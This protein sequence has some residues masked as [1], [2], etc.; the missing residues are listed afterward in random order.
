M[1]L[2]RELLR[3]IRREPVR[4]ML[5]LLGIMI[6]SGAVVLLAST[7]KAAT[8]ALDRASQEATGDDITRVERRTP[9]PAAMARLAPGLSD[10]D[11]RA[12]ADREHVPSGS[13]AVSASIYHQDA[14]VG[15]KTKPVGVQSGGARY[16]RLS[17]F[18]VLHGRWMTPEEDGQRL[19][20]IGHDVWKDLFEEQWPLRQDALVLN[21][22]TRLTVV[23]VLAPRPPIGGG[24]GDGTWMVDRRVIVSNPTFARA[25]APIEEYDEI[26]IKGEPRNGKVPDRIAVAG[27]LSPLVQNLHM[28]VKNFEFDALGKGMQVDMLIA[29]AL[30]V[31]LLGCALVATVVGAVNV[32]NAQLVQ[33]H[34]RTREY[35]IC[36]ALG[37]S[38]S[39][40]RLRVLLEALSC[41]L[42]GSLFGVAG[43]LGLGW[44]LAVLLTR[45]VT[46]WPYEVVPWSIFAAVAGAALAGVLA[47][48]VPAKRAS[49][50]ALA[51]CLRG[52]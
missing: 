31:I 39:R 14:S 28:G 44:V 34:E 50:I 52:E 9:G 5:T 29:G 27:R 7:L 41:T 2:V 40:L 13:T 3:Q 42:V 8:F 26:A 1:E 20:V 19:C 51:E 30:G 6:G 4:M 49:E 33:L 21:R 35:G 36:R 23:G 11:A 32:M 24:D 10:R 46:P 18:D 43:G 17:G 15:P 16:G 12:M 48:W 22:A 25:V 37:L 45:L 38:A 47:G